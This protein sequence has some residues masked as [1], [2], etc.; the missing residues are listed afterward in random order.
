MRSQIESQI[1]D[2][3]RRLQGSDLIGN[4]MVESSAEA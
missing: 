4:E 3:L 1:I 2:I